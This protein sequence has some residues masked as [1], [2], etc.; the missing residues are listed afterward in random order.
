MHYTMKGRC[1]YMYLYVKYV[2]KMCKIVSFVP[3]SVVSTVSSITTT[4]RGTAQQ[5]QATVIFQSP[6]CCCAALVLPTSQQPRARHWEATGEEIQST[7][8]PVQQ[9][10]SFARF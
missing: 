5:T 9:T 6:Q 10:H 7:V 2:L 4:S 8:Q 1:R 3:L